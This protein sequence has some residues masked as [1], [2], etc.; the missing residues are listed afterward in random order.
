[1]RHFLALVCRDW[2]AAI[3]RSRT[4][5]ERRQSIDHKT[6]RKAGCSTLASTQRRKR[7]E[8]Q[9][10]GSVSGDNENNKRDGG[11]QLQLYN[12]HFVCSCVVC[13]SGSKIYSNGRRPQRGRL[14]QARI[15]E[16]PRSATQ[17][18]S[19]SHGATLGGMDAVIVTGFG[20]QR[21]AR[22]I[23]ANHS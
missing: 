17:H 11:F 14:F 20:Q 12:H 19:A 2:I 3:P 9:R 5:S 10:D 1:M 16:I 13:F 6:T 8:K 4:E 15:S 18:R 23:G 7:N 21:R 22:G